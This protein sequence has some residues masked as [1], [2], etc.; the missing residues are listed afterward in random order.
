[1][2]AVWEF[3]ELAK[4]SDPTAQCKTCKKDIPHGGKNTGR[5]NTTNLS[6]HLASQHKE[7]HEEYLKAAAQKNKKRPHAGSHA[8]QPTLEETLEKR[9]TFHRDSKRAKMITEHVAQMIV[10]DN[11]PLSSVNNRGMKRL[12]KALEP[13]YQMPGRT[14]ITTVAMPKNSIK[15]CE[16]SWLNH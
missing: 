16:V 6:T 12:V 3:F 15:T 10:L 11:R 5:Y 8:D 14:Y 7:V 1:M 4:P 13:R 9:E 2:S